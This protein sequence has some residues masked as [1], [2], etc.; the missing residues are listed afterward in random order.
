M[1]G[2]FTG[3]L[4][5]WYKTFKACAPSS[6]KVEFAHAVSGLAGLLLHAPQQPA[7]SRKL[8]ISNEP[9]PDITK[10]L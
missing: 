4:L 2:H 8:D 6:H 9:E 5:L 7:R 3:P 10:K 1:A